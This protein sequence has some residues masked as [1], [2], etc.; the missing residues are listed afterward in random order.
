MAAS[1]HRTTMS[2]GAK[3]ARFRQLSESRD[4]VSIHWEAHISTPPWVS[5]HQASA[6]QRGHGLI[7]STPPLA[8]LRVPVKQTVFPSFRH[9]NP[10]VL[11]NGSE[12]VN[13]MVH[14]CHLEILD[15]EHGV[16]M[17]I[18]AEREGQTI[19]P[20]PRSQANPSNRATY[21]SAD[22][23]SLQVFRNDDS[24]GKGVRGGLG[25]EELVPLV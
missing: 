23:P 6:G 21:G 18:V 14:V 5:Q 8:W 3:Y 20:G 19:R 11:L 17:D 9:F 12:D 16:F 22:P 24:P 4:P 15:T 25:A 1:A 7:C 10:K 2:E 13:D